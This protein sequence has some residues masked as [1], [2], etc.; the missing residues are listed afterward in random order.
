MEQRTGL[1]ATPVLPMRF[2]A[3]RTK[4]GLRLPLPPV[5]V[6]ITPEKLV[7][8]HAVLDS[9]AYA[10]V[11][12]GTWLQMAGIILESLFDG[13]RRSGLTHR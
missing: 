1:G 7:P 8:C 5:V 11:V 2:D 10:S 9:G 6:E 3:T 4:D 12:P 13:S